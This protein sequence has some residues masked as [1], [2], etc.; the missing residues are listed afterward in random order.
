[1]RA[2]VTALA[3]AALWTLPA[4]AA[5]DSKLKAATRQ[6]ESGAKKIGKGVGVGVKETAKGIGN[7][8]VEGAKLTG[9]KVKEASQEA[10]PKVKS[11]WSHVKG[12]AVSF[13][14]GVKGFFSRLFGAERPGTAQ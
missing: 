10:E 7:T 13:G 12:G 8:V 5:D 3:L 6:V 2:F 1:M 9:Q 14:Q 11:T 4:W